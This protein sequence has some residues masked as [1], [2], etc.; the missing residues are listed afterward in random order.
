MIKAGIFGATGYTGFELAQI[1]QRHPQA[2]IV[3]ATSQSNAGQSL[4][5]V[6]PTAPDVKL[7]LGENAPLDEVDVVFLC[8]PHAAAANT[9]VTALQANGHVIDLSADFRIKDVAVYE[10]WYGVTHPAPELLETAVY[11]LT[12]FARKEL[13][14]AK[15]VANPGCYPTSVLLALQPILAAGLPITGPIIADSKSGVSGAGRAPKQNTHF[16]EVANNFSPYNIGRKHRH[17]PEMEQGI[18]S[19]SQNVGA[20]PLIFSPHLL[21]VPR[22]ILST[23]YVSLGGQSNEADIRSLYEETYANE[24][25]VHV[26]PAG[27]LASLG[28]VNHTNRCVMALTLA[29]NTLILTSAIDNLI[30]GAAGQA[31]QNMNVVFELEETQGLIS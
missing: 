29:D 4:A 27:Q 18:A 28:H 20:P 23:I 14:G 6:Y 22:G 17:L 25:F 9:A 3:F 8:L 16:V 10:K 15:L 31:V 1:L 11:G 21:P 7:V 13:P 19:F 26:L 2:D 24:P 30:K 12:E 5:E